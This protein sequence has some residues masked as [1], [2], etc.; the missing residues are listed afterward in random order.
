MVVAIA[1]GFSVLIT[2]L[3]IVAVKSPVENYLDSDGP[4]YTGSYAEEPP[5][6]TG[7]LKVVSWNLIVTAD[8][9]VGVSSLGG[10][11]I[12]VGGEHRIG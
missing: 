9:I 4:I 7:S 5:P 11:Q 1:V 10:V 8:L 12:G 3:F 6:F 2:L